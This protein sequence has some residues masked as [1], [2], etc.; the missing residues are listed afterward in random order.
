MHIDT[1][2]DVGGPLESPAFR[3]YVCLMY[4]L[5]M[6]AHISMSIQSVL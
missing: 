6:H 5:R 3:V 1:T 2:S 4:V